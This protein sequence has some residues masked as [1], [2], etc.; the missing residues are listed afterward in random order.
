MIL[1]ISSKFI[2][3]ILLFAAASN[4]LGGFPGAEKSNIPPG[5]LSIK[6]E[7]LG[8]DGEL[9]D[10]RIT[11]HSGELTSPTVISIHVTGGGSGYSR[12]AL[13][14]GGAVSWVV[15]V[16]KG[17]GRATVRCSYTG[18]R[19]TVRLAGI[20]ETR[21]EKFPDKEIPAAVRET[22]AAQSENILRG[23]WKSIGNWTGADGSMIE[24]RGRTGVLRSL[25][26]HWKKFADA[27]FIS[28]GDALLKDITQTKD[29][30]WNCSILFWGLMTGDTPHFVYWTDEATIKLGVMDVENNH[31]QFAANGNDILVTGT[32]T[33]PENCKICRDGR[34]PCLMGGSKHTASSVFRRL[35]APEKIPAPDP[36]TKILELVSEQFDGTPVK[37]MEPGTSAYG[38][39]EVFFAETGLTNRI[40]D[41]L[42]GVVNH[43]DIFGGRTPLD[44]SGKPVYPEALNSLSKPII[45]ENPD[46]DW[47]SEMDSAYSAAMRFLHMFSESGERLVEG[48]HDN[49]RLTDAGKIL[50]NLLNEPAIDAGLSTPDRGIVQTEMLIL[51]QRAESARSLLFETLSSEDFLTAAYNAR[52]GWQRDFHVNIAKTMS[53]DEWDKTASRGGSP[54]FIAHERYYARSRERYV[55]DWKWMSGDEWDALVRAGRSPVEIA[56]KRRE[57]DRVIRIVSDTLGEEAIKILEE[58]LGLDIEAADKLR[59]DLK[60]LGADPGRAEEMVRATQMLRVIVHFGQ[61][62][63]FSDPGAIEIIMRFVDSWC[64]R[65]QAMDTVSRHLH[66]NLK[67][68]SEKQLELIQRADR[69]GLIEALQVT[70]DLV[71]ES[72]VEL[73]LN[74]AEDKIKDEV[75]DSIKKGW[76]PF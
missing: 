28:E 39:I 31:F 54:Y 9:T 44:V 21:Q 72:I 63:T 35:P 49:L 32:G 15:S 7:R 74:Y 41:F 4:S 20:R 23:I 33:T 11:A 27:G 18:K 17:G 38:N 37:L 10:Y 3:S 5:G 55:D 58:E 13:D 73:V 14:P 51:S 34:G 43:I 40:M 64:K 1:K 19:R 57:M 48:A 67:N 46:V 65:S 12:K 61:E 25:G 56:N 62:H 66:N 50:E 70:D 8:D 76:W 60:E 26:P 45:E 29:Y 2:I 53:A 52:Y 6:V 75:K 42:E 47:A 16:F 59:S 24:I 36:G 68:L 69:E 22:E 30:E 71:D